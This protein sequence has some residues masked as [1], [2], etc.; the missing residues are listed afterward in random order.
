MP[1]TA[2][3]RAAEVLL[4]HSDHAAIIGKHGVAAAELEARLRLDHEDVIRV[5]GRNPE[6][7]LL[8][9]LELLL[10]H[11]EERRSLLRR[12]RAGNAAGTARRDRGHRGRVDP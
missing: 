10:L 2:K 3:E 5:V 7:D 6:V 4:Q 9:D 11:V 8:P 1:V 12:P